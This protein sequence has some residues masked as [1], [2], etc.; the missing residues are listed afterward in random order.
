MKQRP[1]WVFL[2]DVLSRVLRQ[3]KEVKGIQIGK[4]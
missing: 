3:E 1:S 2:K 4:Q